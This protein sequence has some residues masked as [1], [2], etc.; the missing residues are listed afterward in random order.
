MVRSS[1]GDADLVD[2]FV[3]VN[4]LRGMHVKEQGLAPIGITDD[5]THPGRRNLFVL[6]MPPD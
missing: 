4:L 5:P 1:P 3:S 6:L 2:R